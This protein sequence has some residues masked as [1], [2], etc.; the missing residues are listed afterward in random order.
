MLTRRRALALGLSVPALSALAACGPNASSGGSGGASGKLRFVWWGNDARNERTTKAIEA[1]KKIDDKVTI[2]PEPADWSGYW[3][4][5]ATQTAGGKIPDVIQMDESFLREYGDRG[6]LADLEKLGLDTSKFDGDTAQMAVVP[7]QGML[8][9]VAGLNAPGLFVNPAV[10]EAAGVEI[11]D[12]TTWTWDQMAEI[13]AEITAKTEAGTYGSAQP[14]SA[15]PM[16]Q[17]WLRQH[18]QDQFSKDG[19]G[20]D[21]ATLQSFFEYG[22]AMQ[23][24]QAAP[25][26][27]ISVEDGS[28]PLDQNLFSTGKL[29]MTSSWSNQIVAFDKSLNGTVQLL[30]MP[31]Q[32]GSAKDANLWY[33]GSMY[34]SISA[35]SGDQKA[36]LEFVNFLVNSPEAGKILSVERGVPGNTE[37]LDAIKG[38]LDASDQKAVDFLEAIKDEI[39][40]AP[41]LTP[42]GGSIFK[43]ALP[44]SVEPMLFGD[45]TPE[46]AATDVVT[47]LNNGIKK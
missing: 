35:K 10:F 31:S 18:G 5:L 38:D 46:Q 37:V 15:Q 20:F 24:S 43:E 11:P 8:A 42:P 2:S 19:I 3:D 16:M 44:R 39:G 7:D 9:I 23:D 45:K 21:A 29:A 40:T 33:K 27:S 41:F 14:A 12:D 34:W 6:L 32:T 47:E 17:A 22:K 36:A 26:A 1:F 13:A 4:K 25:D 30:R 28:K